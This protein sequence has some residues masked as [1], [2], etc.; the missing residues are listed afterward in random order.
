MSIT[1]IN[2]IAGS[3]SINYTPPS[4]LVVS[5]KKS[6]TLLYSE[7]CPY[8]RKF[9]PIWE[10]SKEL[11]GDQYEF[12][13][14]DCDKTPDVSSKYEFRG[15]PTMILTNGAKELDR[16]VGHQPFE[17]FES[18]IQK[19]KN[20]Q[21]VI[22]KEVTIDKEV[23][24]DN[25]Q[26]LEQTNYKLL[27]M[28]T[29]TC[30]F[31]KKFMPVVDVFETIFSIPIE[32][33]SCINNGDTCRKHNIKGVPTL[34][35][36][37]G[38]DILDTTSG[39]MNLEK[40]I[41][42]VKSSI[43]DIHTFKIEKIDD[44]VVLHKK[45]DV[46]AY[47]NPSCPYCKKLEPVWEESVEKYSNYFNFEN[48]NCSTNPKKCGAIQGVPSIDIVEND[49]TIDQQVGFSPFG[50]FKQ[51]LEKHFTK[52]TLSIIINQYCDFSTKMTEH[53]NTLKDKYPD[54]F[55]YEII[56][57]TFE[58][59]FSLDFFIDTY[60]SVYLHDSTNIIR[61][62]VGYLEEDEFKRWILFE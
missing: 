22:D 45:K 59:N 55:E 6:L 11:Y 39:Y 50:N 51:K 17:T 2:I 47:I 27:L 52:Y 41:S 21:K 34:I 3:L 42:F 46:I 36:Y 8:C 28:Y 48:V 14:V 43:I 53:F 54:I 23:S 15:L 19:D 49:K 7:N 5:N 35:L 1:S 62:S 20:K 32:K 4:S 9:L 56:D 30:S 37:D 10:Q 26:T 38:N 29:D 18:F 16:T 13:F 31:C 61:K 44:D 25:I 40:M 57:N 24:I 60:P 33:V 12:V 58:D